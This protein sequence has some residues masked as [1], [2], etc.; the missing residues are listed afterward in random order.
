MLIGISLLTVITF[1]PHN[2]HPAIVITDRQSG[3]IRINIT[4][5]SIIPGKANNHGTQA[6]AAQTLDI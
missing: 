5:A 3:T 1:I 2:L 4:I 6:H